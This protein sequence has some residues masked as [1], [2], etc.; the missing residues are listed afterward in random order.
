MLK[1]IFESDINYTNLNIQKDKHLQSHTIFTMVWVSSAE[2]IGQKGANPKQ[3]FVFSAGHRE[4][5]LGLT[6]VNTEHHQSHT[7]V[8]VDP[9]VI[10]FINI[11]HSG[12]AA[13]QAAQH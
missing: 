13:S 9:N 11:C 12:T 3:C 6:N 10:V 2:Q 5:F 7:T 1:K 4:G 8:L